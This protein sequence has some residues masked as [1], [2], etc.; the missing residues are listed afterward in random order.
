[1]LFKNEDEPSRK[2]ILPILNKDIWDFVKQKGYALTWFAEDISLETD[3]YDWN[4]KLTSNERNFL[5]YVLAFFAGADVLVSENINGNFIEEVKIMEAQYFYAHQAFMENVHSET[6]ALLIDTYISD[7]TEKDHLFKSLDTIDVIKQKGEWA[8]KYS[9]VNNASFQERLLAF[10]I[11]EGIFFSG[12]FCAIFFFKKK[13]V[14][15]GL[16]LSNDYITRDEGNHTMFASYL[17]KQLIQPLTEQKVHEMFT[18][19]VELEA[20]FINE[21]L[22]VDLI[23]MNKRAM[24]QYIMYVADFWLSELGYSK[25]YNVSNPF[26]FMNLI[27]LQSKTNFFEA[28]VSDYAKATVGLETKDV[29]FGEDSNF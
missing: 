7:K 18:S 21:A 10:L 15:P 9:D 25:L 26:D 1:M 6:Y 17:Y 3:R 27:S 12:S 22:K 19:A 4:H 5:K 14:L 16:C 13:G 2:T 20:E 8:K 23:G 24:K 11:F 29:I 28:R